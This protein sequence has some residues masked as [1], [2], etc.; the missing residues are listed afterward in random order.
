MAL[1]LDLKIGESVNIDND[2][3]TVTLREKSGQ[4][5]RLEIQ[6]DKSIPIRHQKPTA[7]HPAALGLSRQ[8]ST[9]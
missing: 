9:V 3:V 1:Y 8:E 6:A 2:R 4:R 5:A 7:R